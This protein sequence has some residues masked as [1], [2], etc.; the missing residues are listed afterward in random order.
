MR[1][2]INMF[3]KNSLRKVLHVPDIRKNLIFISLLSKH[4]FK[5]VFKSDRGIIYRVFVSKR[6]ATS[7]SLML[8]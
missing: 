4:E 1:G 2:D 8:L 5:M 6:F 3:T 7:G